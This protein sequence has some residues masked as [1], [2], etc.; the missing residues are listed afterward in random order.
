VWAEAD[1]LR[2]HRLVFELGRETV[3]ID[4]DRSVVATLFGSMDSEPL[5]GMVGPLAD[6][7]RQALPFPLPRYG[8][9]FV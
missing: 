8:L 3:E 7:L 1:E 5:A 6:L 2:V 4:G 9:N